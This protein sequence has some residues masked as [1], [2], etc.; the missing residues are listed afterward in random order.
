MKRSILVA[1]VIGLLAAMLVAPMEAGAAKKKKAPK[2]RVYETT[3]TCPCGVQANG[4]GPAWRLGTGEGGV[5]IAV[6]SNEK[7][8][9]LELT[10]DSGL[11]VFFSI[12][13]DV[14]GDG[15]LYEYENGQACGKTAEPVE[16]QPGAAITV[17]IQSGTCDGGPG[18]ATGGTLKATLSA[19]P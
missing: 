13:Q 15:T 9:S 1:L 16:L 11:P 10:D 5:Q 4:Q 17:F 3:Y 12:N 8:L 2:P 7:Y 18:L 14:D 6:A 19:T